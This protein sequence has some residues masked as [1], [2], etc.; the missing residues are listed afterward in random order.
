MFKWLIDLY[1]DWKFER[2]FR[3]KKRKL[4][5]SD[6]FIYDNKKN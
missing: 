5:K 2:E 6:P 1:E 3:K 4:L